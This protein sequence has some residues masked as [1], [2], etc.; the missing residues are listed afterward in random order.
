MT[1][2]VVKDYK[3][4]RGW[5]KVRCV[6]GVEQRSKAYVVWCNLRKRCSPVYQQAHPSYDGCSMSAT[7]GDFQKFAEWAISQV[8]YGLDGYALDKDILVATNKLYAED[9]C[10]FVPQAL[11]N[12][13]THK[14]ATGALLRGV[15]LQRPGKWRVAIGDGVRQKHVAVFSSPEAASEAYKLEKKKE[16]LRWYERLKAGEFVVDPR[17]VECMRT[18]EYSDGN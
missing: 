6:G 11:N 8:G 18:W 5:I 9:T 4:Q 7:F 17:V 3:D 15:Y 1:S 13:L 14:K 2:L 10:V 12:F 16:A